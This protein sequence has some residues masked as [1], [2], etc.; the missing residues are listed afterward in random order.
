[1]STSPLPKHWKPEP[2]QDRIVKHLLATPGAA[3]WARIGAGKTSAALAA[4]DVMRR[5]S[6]YR[7]LVVAPKQVARDVW[8]QEAALWKEFAHLRVA[9]L[10]G[11]K[12]HVTLREPADVYVINYDGLAWLAQETVRGWRW[13]D[14][15]V[16]DEST[17]C[18]NTNTK[19]F[20]ILRD[21]VAPR[22]KRRW[23]LS[24]KP[25]P[26]G[27]GNLFGQY[28]LIDGGERLGRYITHF[29]NQ[30]MYP[31]GYGGYDWQLLPGAAERIRE[32]VQDITIEVS[33]EDL[34]KTL[35]KLVVRD[36]HV[37]LPPA[38]MSVYRKL[39][40]QFVA[41]L[42]KGEVTAVNAAAQTQKLRQIASGSVF[43]TH[44]EWE[45]VHDERLEALDG[46]LG[47]EPLLLFAEFTHEFKRIKE[48]FPEAVIFGDASDKRRSEIILEWN[49]GNIELLCAHP[50]SAAHG[51]NLQGG[52]NTLLWYSLL[53][54]LDLYD[55]AIGRLQRKGQKAKQVFVHR[56]IAPGTI[57]EVMCEALLAKEQGQNAF[58]AGLRKHLLAKSRSAA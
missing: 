54:D 22:M 44:P 42:K 27:E 28:R 11:P 19:R 35:P 25:M 8:A 12:K 30:F 13:P 41:L 45:A 21:H 26:N 7:M 32:R 16:L 17:K 5:R 55:Q 9:L 50:A 34:G 14:V 23:A 38:A 4:F 6:G 37:P 52:G 49:A 18:R 46:L 10:H 47:N 33:A 24:G 43:T 29:R 31:S 57:D 48:R 20:K 51:L 15:L 3:V 39:E 58:L 2:Y 53:Y 56:F 40:D 1:M 36:I